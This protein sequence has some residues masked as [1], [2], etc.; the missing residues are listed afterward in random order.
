MSTKH[1]PTAYIINYAALHTHACMQLIAYSQE[2]RYVP[3]SSYSIICFALSYTTDEKSRCRLSAIPGVA[4]SDYINASYVD[5][6]NT[7]NYK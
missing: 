5:V 1:S 2:R 6:S 4:G 3:S 7:T